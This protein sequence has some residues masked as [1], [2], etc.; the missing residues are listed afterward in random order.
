MRA[1]ADFTIEPGQ[2]GGGNVLHFSGPMVVSSL[3]LVD[4]RLR[5]I[6]DPVDEID[7]S[8]VERMDTVGAWTVWRLSQQLGA[9][10]VNCRDEA[11]RL[12]NDAGATGMPVVV[13]F[14]AEKPNADIGPFEPQAALDHL[15]AARPRP[16]PTDRPAVYARV[17]ETLGQMPGASVAVLADGLAAKGDEQ[18]FGKLLSENAANVVWAVPDRTGPIGLAAAEND[19]DGFSLTAIRAPGD[20]AP[21][22]LAAGAFDDKGRRIADTTL[23]FPA[24]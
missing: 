14:T 22:S 24:C 17:A 18:A 16:I 19:V 9:K 21:R 11:E 13:A 4:R 6:A 7:V 2:G 15:R 23:T 3:G 12:I 20:P 1:L 10:I 8:D 5:Q